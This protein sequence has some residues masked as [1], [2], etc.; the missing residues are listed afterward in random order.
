MADNTVLSTNVGTGDTIRTLE[1][2]SSIKWPVGVTAFATS[3]GTPDVLSVVTP[4]TGL[5]VRLADGSGYLTALPVTDNSGSLTVDGTVAATQSGTWTVQPGNTANTTAWL[6]TGT[7]G[8]FPA[9][10][11]GSWTVTANAG[12]GT[13][14][15][16]GSVASGA[17]ATANPV[18]IGGQ[19]VSGFLRPMATDASG[20]PQVTGPVANSDPQAG[21][22]FPVGGTDGSFFRY[23]LT[24]ASGRLYV[25][26]NGTVTVGTHAV[27]Q[28][29]TWTVTANAGTGTFAVSAASLPLP[30]GAAT[31]AK[32]PALG[33]AGTASADVITVQGIASMTALKVDGSA[34]TQPVSGTVTANAGSGTMAVSVAAGATTIAKAEDVASADADVGVPAMAVRKATPANTSGTDGDYEMLQMSAGRLWVS[35]T[36]DTA[37]PAGTNAIGKLASNSGVTIGAVELAA[38]QTLATVTTVSTVTTCSTVTT[39]ANGQTAHDGAATGSPLRVGAKA[40]TAISGVTL[41]ADGDATDLYAGVDGVLIVR[42]HCNLEDIVSERA[43]NTD[44]ASTAFVSGLAAPGAGVR[45]YI[46]SVTICNSSASFCTVDLRDGSA[47]SVLWTFP[48]PA[49]GG[50]THTFNP[51]LKLTANTALAYDASAATTTL[52]VS[53][54][55]FK[56]KV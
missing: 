4:T 49:T 2:G 55:G 16:A 17:I 46:T 11:S 56:S 9:T 32:Q 33:T 39:L 40:E 20:H 24:D 6:V 21:N 7:G 36:V 22:L 1:D 15:V 50:V 48:V 51:P 53:A 10:Q 3:V 12:T 8:T 18:L 29:G 27:T 47:G 5:P 37:L 28:S 38:A 30:S 41:V 52:T 14:A 34:V 35:A 43:T 44:G 26:V 19:D 31:A 13:F 23:M 54:L 45:L 25:N 42:P